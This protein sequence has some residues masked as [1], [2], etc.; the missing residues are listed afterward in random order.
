MRGNGD[1]KRLMASFV[2]NNT[3]DATIPIESTG[4]AVIQDWLVSSPSGNFG[5]IIAADA[6]TDGISIA[7]RKHSTVAFRPILHV[8]FTK[9]DLSSFIVHAKS[10]L[11]T[12][13]REIL[14]LAAAH[15]G[16]PSTEGRNCTSKWGTNAFGRR[17]DS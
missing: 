2:A 14:K 7:T 9:P 8:E 15:A 17:V 5:I 11:G 1:R 12:G 3:G 10:W 13:A 4:L 16:R 6:T